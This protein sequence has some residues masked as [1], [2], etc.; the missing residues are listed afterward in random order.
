MTV[1][2][3]FCTNSTRT[4][5]HTDPSN[6]Y[7]GSHYLRELTVLVLT[8]VKFEVRNQ[9]Q[10]FRTQI[11]VVERQKIISVR[12]C[13]LAPFLPVSFFTYKVLVPTYNVQINT[14]TF[15]EVHGV[16]KVRLI[17]QLNIEL[18]MEIGV[19]WWIVSNFRS[20][21][22]LTTPLVPLKLIKLLQRCLNSLLDQMFTLIR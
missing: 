3:R 12:I 21:K 13:Y 11:F 22:T 18:K 16:N 15:N 9:S 4:N 14:Q 2:M 5:T 7:S 10:Q 8:R 6:Y 20:G 1:W 17:K 19:E